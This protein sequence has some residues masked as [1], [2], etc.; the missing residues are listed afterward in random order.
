MPAVFLHIGAAK[1]GTTYLQQVLLDSRAALAAQG[2]LVPGGYAEAHFEAALDLRGLAFGGAEDPGVRGRWDRLVAESLAW[3]GRAVAISHELFGG[4]LPPVVSAI[5]DAFADAELHV[6]LTARDLGRQVPAM[7][8][9]QVKNGG[10]LTFERYVRRLVEGKGKAARTFWRQ[11]DLA[12]VAERWCARVPPERFH[13][14]MVP[15]AGRSDPTLLWQRFASV[16]GADPAGADAARPSANRSLSYAGAEL[17]RRVNAA[18]GDR[19]AWPAYETTVKGWFA[20]ELLVS[21]D[22]GPRP[23]VPVEH[24]AELADRSARML[25]RLRELGVDTV[26]DLAELTDDFGEPVEAPDPDTVIGAAADT[27]AEVLRERSERH[28]TGRGNALVA[29]ARRSPAL[30]RLPDG[31]QSWLKRRVNR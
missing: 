15:P 18:L 20:E 11:Q 27:L 22:A 5:A 31:V 29:R 1:T 12:E 17:V 7:W 6:V 19:M 4:S 25:Q 14:V 3:H 21:L 23:T 24:R 13:L 2:V 16:V 8:Q 26:G 9:E 30:R 10:T 28:W